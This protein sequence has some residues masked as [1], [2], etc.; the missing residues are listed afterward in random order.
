MDR[1][2]KII[3][4]L[5][6][7][8]LIAIIIT[9][10]V[11]PKPVNWKDSF[12]SADKIPFGCYVLYNELE[13][14]FPDKT[15]KKIDRSAYLELVEGDIP[16]STYLFINS[17]LEFDEQ[18][19]QKLLDYVET[20]NNVFLAANSFDYMLRDSLKIDT[21]TAYGLTE[22]TITISLAN[23]VFKNKG[24]K[25]ARGINESYFSS[26]DTINTTI[27][28]YRNATKKKEKEVNFIKLKRG[29]GS[30]Y[31]S[32]LPKAYTNYYMLRGNGEYVANTLSYFPSEVIFWDDYKKD[33]RI[34]ID[35]PMRYVLNQDALKWTYYL[36]ISTIFLFVLFK[37]KREQR[38]IPVVKPLENA[39]VAFTQT[40][41][42]LYFQHKD[43]SNIVRK[44]I[45]Y[46]L[47]FVRSEF[48]LNTERL[49]NHFIERLA[50][51]SGK[52]IEETQVLIK[53]IEKL[54]S[55][56]THTEQQLIELNKKI[57]SYKNT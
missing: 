53:Y 52:T 7:A 28:G 6:L 47:E 44:K 35:S 43:Y 55:N 16:S 38:I 32:T 12:T 40:I 49:D 54:R 50:I 26:F 8:V 2:S 17:Y 5:F 13:S 42:N 11:R 29:S 45:V 36:T 27:L 9:E 25:Y 4:G 46:F 18:E 22:D 31:I 51:K 3:I 14:L 21:Y 37:G 23:S 33:G 19:L 15:I 24:Y 34:I 20:G 10:V 48:F 1:K 56:T 39:S 57:E 30:F 41:G